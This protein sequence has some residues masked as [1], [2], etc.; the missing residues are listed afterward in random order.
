MKNATVDL[1][2]IVLRKLD[3]GLALS[4][5]GTESAASTIGCL[6]LYGLSRICS[7]TR[8]V[9]PLVGASEGA[10]AYLS[11]HEAFDLRLGPCERLFHCLSLQLTHPH[12]GQHGL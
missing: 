10:V 2:C 6:P 1:R 3:R 8:A 12:L 9:R 5:S 7:C 11:A 4:L